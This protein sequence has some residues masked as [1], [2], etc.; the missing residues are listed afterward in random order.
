LPFGGTFEARAWEKDFVPIRSHIYME[1]GMD[2]VEIMMGNLEKVFII[3]G[4]EPC[5]CLLD[6]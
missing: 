2:L 4:I 6:G 5:H 1:Y 3:N